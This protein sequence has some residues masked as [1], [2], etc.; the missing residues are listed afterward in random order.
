MALAQRGTRSARE[1]RLL[2]LTQETNLVVCSA[3]T[4]R[5]HP[6]LFHYT[7]RSGLEG[8]L[9]S[10][11]LRASHF[12]D[13]NDKREVWLLRQRLID[14]LAPRF[15]A[16]SPQLNRH[17]RLAFKAQGRGAGGARRMLDALYGATFDS[18]DG[19]TKL[20]A[21]M[22]SFST[23]AADGDFEREHGLWSQWERYAGPDGY[24][25]VFDTAEMCEILGREFDRDYWVR[26]ALEP[27]RYSAEDA[28][29]DD[30][31][32]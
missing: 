28:S 13:L 26:L 29:I 2:K 7:K 16:L 32:A 8:I 1:T 27:V 4:K 9:S 20:E 15:D 22:T 25:I 31:S 6:E 18:K 17:R 12:K 23:H 10:E 3:E 24:C 19:P 5:D 30:S 14:A 11:T 21:F